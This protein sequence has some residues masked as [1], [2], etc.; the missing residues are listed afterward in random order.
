M[1]E[2]QKVIV[3]SR[4]AGV[5]YGVL[6]SNEGST[7]VLSQARQMWR[8]R[9]AKGGT[10]IDC[11]VYGVVAKDCKFSTAA[12]DVTVFNVCAMILVSSAGAA[13]LDAVAETVWK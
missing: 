12:G 9:A 6:V 8:W 2:G 4:D 13:L 3:R 11:A 7:V 1:N 10:L 5:L